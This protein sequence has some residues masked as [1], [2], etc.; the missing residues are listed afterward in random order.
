LEVRYD[1]RSIFRRNHRY[2]INNGN[3]PGADPDEEPGRG[4]DSVQIEDSFKSDRTSPP[5]D[6]SPMEELEADDEA[7]LPRSTLQSTISSGQ[8]QGSQAAP[9]RSTSAA[10]ER[11]I[12]QTPRV[13]D[14]FV[15]SPYRVTVAIVVPNDPV[16]HDPST[17]SAEDH[18]P[19]PSSIMQLR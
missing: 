16:N 9:E 8:A 7:S 12:E 11:G 17:R 13:D 3:E 1:E 10:G 18:T 14:E 6:N 4:L 19:R 5:E 15:P 2:G